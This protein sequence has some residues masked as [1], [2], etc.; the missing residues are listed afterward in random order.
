ML[1]EFEWLQAVGDMAGWEMNRTFNMGMGMALVVD[2]TVALAT[3][4]W[5]NERLPGCK[6]V[7][8]VTESGVVTHAADEVTFD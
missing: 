8:V 6:V 4:E 7:G 5:L 2:A 3:M 1:P